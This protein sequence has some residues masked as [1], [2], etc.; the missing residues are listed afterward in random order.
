M[1]CTCLYNVP[2]LLISGLV[3]GP[4]PG[5]G[6]THRVYCYPMEGASMAM[7]SSAYCVYTCPF[8][9]GWY[10]GARCE[11]QVAKGLSWKRKMAV[12]TAELA[13]WPG[14]YSMSALWVHVMHEQEIR[15][16]YGE[17]VQLYYQCDKWN[18]E[19]VEQ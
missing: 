10:W 14:S 17:P 4:N 2:K 12:G 16:Q 18:P 1:H 5:K 3:P 11:L 9:D 6:N 13:A 7:K 15:T 19:L 8:E